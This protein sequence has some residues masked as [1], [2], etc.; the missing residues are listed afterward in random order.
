M[1]LCLL[2]DFPNILNRRQHRFA[3]V[4]LHH[5]RVFNHIEMLIN[6]IK[7]FRLQQRQIFDIKHRQIPILPVFNVLKQQQI[8]KVSNRK[9]GN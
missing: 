5:F 4:S 1:W 3:V 7:W 6:H 2:F 8:D 9:G